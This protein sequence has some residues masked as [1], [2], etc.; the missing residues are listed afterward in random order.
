MQKWLETGE[1]L[2]ELTTEGGQSPELHM[3]TDKKQLKKV[4]RSSM[5]L[6]EKFTASG[7]FDKLKARLVAGGDGQDKTLYD[8]LSSPGV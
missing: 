5:F 3:R 7:E 1:C 4:I 2:I 8:N 6:T